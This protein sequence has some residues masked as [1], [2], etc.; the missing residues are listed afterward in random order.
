MAWIPRTSILPSTRDRC[1]IA[2]AWAAPGQGTDPVL[3]VVFQRG[4]ADALNLVIP[5]GDADY[6][7]LRP[8][9]Q[10]TPGTELDLNGPGSF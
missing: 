2:T 5:R 10:V 1:G 3:V 6:Y 8:T 4:A 7:N 9:I